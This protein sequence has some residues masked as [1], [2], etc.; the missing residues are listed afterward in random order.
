MWRRVVVVVVA[1]VVVLCRC[2]AKE[3][4]VPTTWYSNPAYCSVGHSKN[5]GD[6]P[7]NTRIYCN[8]TL[9]TEQ[10]VDDLLN[11]MVPHLPSLTT[12][13]TTHSHLL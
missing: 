4:L 9:P 12:Y 8:W 3:K 10:R 7:F 2:E 13:N 1:L 5:C 11:W 6:H